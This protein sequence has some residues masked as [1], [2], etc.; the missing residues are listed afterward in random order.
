MEWDSN[1]WGINIYNITRSF[2]FNNY[3][4]NLN[5]ELSSTPFIVQALVNDNDTEYTNFLESI[6]FRFIENKINLI[7]KIKDNNYI[8]DQEV[9][10]EVKIEDFKEYKD[11][12]YDLYGKVTRFEFSS[13]KKI[14]EFYYKWVIKSI[15]GKLDDNCIGYYIEGNLGG[16]ITYK[17]KNEKL[18]IGLL[19]VFPKYQGRNISQHLLHYVYSL[20]LENKCSEI[21]VSTQ[22]KNIKAIN[23][24]IKNGFFIDNINQWYY[25]KEGI[26]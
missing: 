7:K 2:D 24:Y 18:I 17:I 14:N 13:K 23:A 6:G 21:H 16:F 15:E 22:G 11:K 25:F 5:K 26:K 1:F 9:F 20:S 10:R 4:F 12:F 19:G 3:D 8:I